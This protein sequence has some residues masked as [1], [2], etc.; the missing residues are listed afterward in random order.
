[1]LKWLSVIFNAKL[2]NFLTHWD[3]SVIRMLFQI[4]CVIDT[5]E[6]C[7]EDLSDVSSEIR[8]LLH[9]NDK[10]LKNSDVND[11]TMEI[12]QGNNCSNNYSIQTITLY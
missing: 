12:F 2:T 5:I 9:L 1:M 10:S 8:T 11:Q 6:S 4:N 7:W 3:L